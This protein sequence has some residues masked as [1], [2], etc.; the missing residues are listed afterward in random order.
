MT[1]S[2]SG[3]ENQQKDRSKYVQLY[4]T[5]VSLVGFG[6]VILAFLKLPNPYFNLALF[7]LLAGVTEAFGVELFSSSHSRI[8]VSNIIAVAS[9]LLFGWQ[10][11]V[12]VQLA[13]GV[14][15]AI[16]S[17]YANHQLGKSRASIIRRSTFNVGMLVISVAAGG[18]MYTAV[19]GS[20]GSVLKISNILPLILAVA[21]NSLTNFLLLIGVISIQ[22]GQKFLHIWR[23]DFQWVLPILMAGGVIG[24][25]A[26]GMAFEMFDLLG[27]AVFFLP[28]FLINYSFRMYVSNT[29]DYVN[30][31]EEMNSAL[32]EA[33]LGLLEALGRVID[34][35]DVFTYGHSKQVSI[36]AKEISEKMNLST[37]QTSEIVRAALIH[38]IGKVGI[39]E[40]ILVKPGRL[41][42][43]ERIIMNRHPEIG[44]NIISEMKGLQRLVPLVKFHHERW[45][46]RGYP[47]HLSGEDIPLGARVL[48]L[49]DSVEAMA[50]D[51]TYHSR[52]SF[53]EI[54]AEVIRCSGDQFDPAVVQAFLLVCDEK[55]KELLNN[56]AT[57]V[58]MGIQ[59]DGA[60][61]MEEP[62]VPY[63]KK[64]MIMKPRV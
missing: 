56:S 35:Y 32:D 64:G 51:R 55:G 23:R 43:E 12:I 40:S 24:G 48:A 18:W 61:L 54:R 31:L 36:Y 1:S 33:N 5:A 27:L 39:K 15:A 58:A 25:G 42:M 49:A 60:V 20:I 57:L 17:T 59:A 4:T 37:D 41:S 28:I 10:A 26:L 22:T 47:S 9:F 2:K 11:G 3:A 14:T 34:A 45:D 16:V 62:K 50:S 19:G 29:K 7:A 44:A 30:K 38:D 53:D 21:V 6:V 8:S 52:L 13:T 63:L 46:G